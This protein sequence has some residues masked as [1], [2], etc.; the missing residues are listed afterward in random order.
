ML[1]LV[2]MSAL[3]RDEEGRGRM[4]VLVQ[5]GQEE[6]DSWA[7]DPWE[8]DLAVVQVKECFFL[9]HVRFF[10]LLRYF[11]CPAAKIN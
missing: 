10:E 11:A 6:D 9:F 5:G 1:R 3:L 8:E 4:T 7:V 2:N